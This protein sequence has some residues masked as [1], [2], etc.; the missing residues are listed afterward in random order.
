MSYVLI[1][2]A[3]S[4]IAKEVA[5][6]YANAGYDLYLASR[7]IESLAKFENDLKVR[8]QIDI[9]LLEFDLL[10]FDSHESFY[11]SLNPKPTIT[12]CVA[13]YLGEQKKAQ[14]DFNEAK[15]IIDTNYTGCVSILNIVAND[16]E[17]NRV[18]S[19]VGVSSVAGDRGRKSNYIY[20]SSKAGFSAY[21][22]G[23]R[24][25]L[26]DFNVKVLTVKPGFVYTKMTEN[27]DLPQKLTATPEDV[28]K[29]IFKAEQSGKDVLYTKWIWRFIML[30]IKHIPEWI[31]KKM[32]I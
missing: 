1:I 27:L 14:T 2:G 12:I 13:G 18:G 5:K 7:E 32:S 4:D 25:R 28:A 21:L 15:K 29:D 8:S 16:Y 24:N 20:G 31:F 26:H 17:K 30:I 10:D 22:S 11:N 23:L 3:K 9:K 19:I 6:E